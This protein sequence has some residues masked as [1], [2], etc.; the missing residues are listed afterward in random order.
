MLPILLFRPLRAR[1]PHTATD[2]EH[3]ERLVHGYG[4]DTLA[5]FALRDDKSF[6]FGSDG[7]AMIAYTYLGGYALVSGDPIGAPDSVP[8]GDRRVPRDVRR[9]RL[10]TR[11]S[12]RSA[13]PTSPLYAARGFRSFYLGDEAIM[14][15]DRFSL[16]GAAHKSLRAAV[17]RV[18]RRYRFQLITEANA[19]ASLV[20]QLERDQRALAGQGARA[21]LHDVA[22][23]GRR[24]APAPTRS[25]CCASRWTRTT[26]RRVP[27]AGARLRRRTSATPST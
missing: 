26:S 9:A 10:D 21:R 20:E 19:P 16:A 23:P 4:W 8:A 17:R 15:C 1:R 14:R 2:W 11:R 6:F 27:A 18:G 12:W 13:R 7:E 22:E 5:Y 24:A 25:S 3:A